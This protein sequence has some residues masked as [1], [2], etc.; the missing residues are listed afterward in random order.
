MLSTNRSKNLSFTSCDF[1]VT[2][3]R[4][5]IQLDAFE[6]DGVI[7]LSL[8]YCIG[9]FKKETMEKLLQRYI[10]II[11]QVV[12]SPEIKLRGLEKIIQEKK[13]ILL[14]FNDDL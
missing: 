5:E 6:G 3:S 11:V 8:L 4:F 2:D 1:E 12:D 10:N 7:H 13:E 9:L 14:D